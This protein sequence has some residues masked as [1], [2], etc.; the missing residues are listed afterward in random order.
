MGIL[1]PPAISPLKKLPNLGNGY[2]MI[3]RLR[4]Q[5]NSIISI[6]EIIGFRRSKD[7]QKDDWIFLRVKNMRNLRLTQG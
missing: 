7:P 5:D 2:A 6:P 1:E 3:Q 4:P